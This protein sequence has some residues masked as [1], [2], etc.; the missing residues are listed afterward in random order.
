MYANR[1]YY[2][3]VV[4]YGGRPYK[5]NGKWYT[6]LGEIVKDTVAYFNAIRRNN[7]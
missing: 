4:G 2:K 1:Y 7:R 3:G 6:P 5:E